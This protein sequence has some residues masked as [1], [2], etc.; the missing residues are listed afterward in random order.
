MCFRSSHKRA[1]S[2][3]P[4]KCNS[5][6]DGQI[7]RVFFQ[8]LKILQKPNFFIIHLFQ[9]VIL[10]RFWFLFPQ[11]LESIQCP[12]LKRGAISRE[13]VR[14]MNLQAKLPL[15]Y[16]DEQLELLGHCILFTI[17]RASKSK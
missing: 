15:G 10:G 14:A 12:F 17:L 3:N 4:L 5:G 16:G 6:T 2:V 11:T 8:E 1:R 9:T 7:N 13:L